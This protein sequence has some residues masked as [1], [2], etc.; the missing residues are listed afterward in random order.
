MKNG[1]TLF[2][3]LALLGLGMVVLILGVGLLPNMFTHWSEEFSS[4][5]WTR[6]PAIFG[7]A[8][9]AIVFWVALY[10]L[11]NLLGLIEKNKAFTKA[12][13]RAMKNVKR[14][15][16]IIS[17][18]YAAW[19]PLIF[20]IADRE[21]APGLILIFGAIFVAVP[22][23]VA[24]FAGVAQQLFQNAIDIKKENDLTV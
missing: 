24:I 8:V 11:T 21:D 10:Q 19:T 4:M 9:S 23:I 14:C 18:I 5:M 3:R 12:S 15:G 6:Y 13:V 1:S 22:F 2:L 7:L 16:F 17:G 20:H